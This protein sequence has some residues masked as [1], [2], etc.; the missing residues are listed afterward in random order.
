MA[1][2]PDVIVEVID[3]F[4]RAS[5]G[6]GS[7]M[8]RLMT[9]F[10]YQSSSSIRSARARVD[11]SPLARTTPPA[12]QRAVHQETAYWVKGPLRRPLWPCGHCLLDPSVDYIVLLEHHPRCSKRAPASCDGCQSR[13][14][15]TALPME[16]TLRARWATIVRASHHSFGRRACTRPTSDLPSADSNYDGVRNGLSVTS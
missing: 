5:D 8:Y 6:S 13:I 11:G 7:D 4:L 14:Q 9:N 2:R 10:E 12:V 3:E 16:W 1:Q 15:H